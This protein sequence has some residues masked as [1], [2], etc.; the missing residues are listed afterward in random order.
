[1]RL[2]SGE[3]YKLTRKHAAAPYQ[4]HGKEEMSSRTFNGK[5]HGKCR[6]DVE[7]GTEVKTN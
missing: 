5:R 7:K 4:S 3:H 6:T 2:K 1:M